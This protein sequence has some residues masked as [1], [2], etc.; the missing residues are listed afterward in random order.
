MV[1]SPETCPDAS[2]HASGYGQSGWLPVAGT[3]RRVHVSER[4]V[5]SLVSPF[6]RSK[7][8]F[9]AASMLPW[10]AVA[11]AQE[12]VLDAGVQ[13]SV[14]SP[15]AGP[16]VD[17]LP[18][19]IATDPP[20]G[21]DGGVAP[22]LQAP[23]ILPPP[24]LLPVG[25]DDALDVTVRGD[26]PAGPGEFARHGTG[27]KVNAPLEQIPATVSV[28]DSETI[29]ERGVT[30]LQDALSLLPGL[31]PMWTYGG[32]QATQARGFQALM[33]FDGRR[34]SR[35]ILS[36]SSPFTGLFDLDRGTLRVEI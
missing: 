31:T 27:S 22:I 16:S 11:S 26:R 10:A 4:K 12:S 7:L 28:V 3:V 35:S 29:R 9:F 25:D 20:S 8:F 36:G 18:E 30:D 1:V 21:L 6:R 23:V 33:L 19:S 15:D 32:F 17:P 2:H 5:C 24:V 14:A 34:D 13:P